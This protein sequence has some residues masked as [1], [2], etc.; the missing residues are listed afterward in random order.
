MCSSYRGVN[1]PVAQADIPRFARYLANN[2]LTHVEVE[3]AEALLGLLAQSSLLWGA[4]TAA[5]LMLLD[6][7]LAGRYSGADPTSERSADLLFSVE[8][9]DKSGKLQTP[10]M[11]ELEGPATTFAMAAVTILDLN[12]YLGRR[13]GLAF[14]SRCSCKSSILPVS[15]LPHAIDSSREWQ[16]RRLGH[17]QAGRVQRVSLEQAL[18]QGFMKQVD[19]GLLQRSLAAARVFLG[20]EASAAFA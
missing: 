5:L 2:H 10:E 14:W 13:Y 16:L 18:A 8:F 7:Q 4:H 1:L 17:D 20:T 9:R 6:N 19:A 11:E 15:E 12:T 3:D